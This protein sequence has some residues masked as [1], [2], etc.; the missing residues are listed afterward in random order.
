VNPLRCATVAREEGLLPLGTAGHHRGYLLVDWPLPWPKDLGDV[1]ELAPLYEALEGTGIR[2]QGVVPAPGDDRTLV[3]HLRPPGAG[4][5]GYERVARVVGAGDVVEAA[6][7]LVGAAVAAGVTSRVPAGVGVGPS[8]GAG[9]GDHLDLGPLP[10]EAA[11][12]GVGGDLLVCTHGRRDACC[13][14]LGTSL[15]MELLADPVVA[16]A[17]Y[18]VGRTSHTG[19]HR[20]APTALVLPEATMWAFLDADL[21]ARVVRRSGPVEDVLGAY[22][23]STGIG[24]PAVQAVEREA[25]AQVGWS[26]LD[27]RRTGEDLGEGRARVTGESPQGEVRT[28][29]AE[30]TGNPRPVPDCGKP[31]AEARKTQTEPIILTLTTT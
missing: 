13:G 29:E 22:R 4:F 2:L 8:G 1:P 21:T 25:F 19:G 5:G 23:G 15:H 6:V 10:G 14:S 27:W 9:P 12:D 7:A 20:F 26:W 28:W 31:L 30:L 16:G 11:T 18:R 17:G 24:S 3:L